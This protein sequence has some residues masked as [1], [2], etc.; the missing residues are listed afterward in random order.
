[1]RLNWL[2]LSSRVS[3]FMQ[4]RLTFHRDCSTR[5]TAVR[6]KWILGNSSLQ[7]CCYLLL[8]FF[9]ARNFLACMITCIRDKGHQD[10]DKLA[11][12]PHILPL[13]SPLEM[14]FI[15]RAYLR[16]REL[17]VQNTY[18]GISV[19]LELHRHSWRFNVINSR[20]FVVVLP[21]F[22]YTPQGQLD[23]MKRRLIRSIARTW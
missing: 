7:C 15:D 21:S 4:I 19:W 18:R 13:A 17:W 8:F 9:V 10:V 11:S 2:G 6:Q 22:C 5:R 3:N 14:R 16:F 23:L 1:M 12:M 20:E